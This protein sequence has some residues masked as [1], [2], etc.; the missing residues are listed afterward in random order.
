MPKKHRTY[1][2]TCK[3]C[4]KSFRDR[5]NWSRNPKYCSAHCY[6]EARHESLKL[7]KRCTQCGKLK[8]RRYFPHGKPNERNGYKRPYARSRCR[9]CMAATQRQRWRNPELR[10]QMTL[11]TRRR[12]LKQSYGISPQD[13]DAMLSNQS[14]QCAICGRTTTSRRGLN[15]RLAV[16]HDHNTRKVRG[17]LCLK[18]NLGIGNFN[19]DPSLLQHA[20]SYLLKSL[21]SCMDE[22]K[23]PLNSAQKLQEKSERL[24]VF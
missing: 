20:A 8:L 18:C 10:K 2:F 4:K 12:R 11:T 24:L 3:Q 1:S 17:L 15:L 16:D 22:Q 21:E 19:H 6:T 5:R 9:K 23:F 7:P 13:Y 14:G